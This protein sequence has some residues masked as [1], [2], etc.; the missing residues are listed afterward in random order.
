MTILNFLRFM[1]LLGIL[2]AG[3]IGVLC[4][5]NQLWFIGAGNFYIA[6]TNLRTLIGWEIQIV[7]FRRRFKREP[8]NLSD[9]RASLEADLGKLPPAQ[10]NGEG[11]YMEQA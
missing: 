8:V 2:V 3:T 9:L 11:G 7:R 5:L 10:I 6:G 4:F 1:L